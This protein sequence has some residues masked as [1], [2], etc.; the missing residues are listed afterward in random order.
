M[1]A[2]VEIHRKRLVGAL[3]HEVYWSRGR[4]EEEGRIAYVLLD[5]DAKFQ[6]KKVCISP[7]LPPR[8]PGRA[9]R[10]SL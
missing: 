9:R 4:A 5:E 6:L 2:I 7:G 3:V 8:I 10:A 1:K